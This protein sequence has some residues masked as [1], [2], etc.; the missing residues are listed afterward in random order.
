VSE[1]TRAEVAEHDER[2]DAARI[3]APLLTRDE[4][5]WRLNVMVHGALFVH[6]DQCSQDLRCHVGDA[7]LRV[8][9]LML[10]QV[11]VQLPTTGQFAHQVVRLRCVKVCKGAHDV[12]VRKPSACL[13]FVQCLLLS[14][15][16]GGPVFLQ[17]LHS[18]GN[19]SNTVLRPINGA[20]RAR[21][22]NLLLLV[23]LPDVSIG[24]L[25][26]CAFESCDA[27]G[28]GRQETG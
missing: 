22:E 18:H 24:L 12:R 23:N 7:T 26:N 21:P 1:A 17:L 8:E 3:A 15:G 6:E 25:L 13:E 27:I 5:V 28:C 4:N 11:V 20:E 10:R 2:R 9:V 16:F 19:A 14:T